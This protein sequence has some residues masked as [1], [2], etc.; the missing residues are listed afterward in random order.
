[1]T[2]RQ[3]LSLV[4]PLLFLLLGYATLSILERTGAMAGP[5][6][7]GDFARFV[8]DRMSEEFAYGLGD[9]RAQEAAYF[10]AL[11]AYVKAFDPRSEIIPPWELERS[12]QESSGQYVGIGVR[13]DQPTVEGDAITSVRISG[14][15]PKGPAA[16]AGVSVGDVL[17]GVEGVAVATICADG[18]IAPLSG[19]IMGERG[20]TVTLR[21]RGAAGA[22]RDVA[23]VRDAIDEG[24][25]FGVRFLDGPGRIGY[26]R[27]Q[28]FHADT[29][30]AVEEAVKRL[31][32]DGMK[33]LVL[34]VRQNP[35]GLL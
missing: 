28:S 8:R 21:L 33:G 17:V 14:V 6:W 19:A 29:G 24:S 34:D 16:K 11:N 10:Q 31:L 30:R 22:E 26:L 20:T 12:R 7:D 32:A 4:V 35:G 25:V 2:R 1:V 18:Q 9:R 27:I 15:K 3:F 23:I 5:P 13:V